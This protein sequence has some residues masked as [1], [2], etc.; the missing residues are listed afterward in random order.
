ML[1]RN[2]R[3]EV[4]EFLPKSEKFLV[5][6]EIVGGSSRSAQFNK[7]SSLRHH[8]PDFAI[9]RVLRE[10]PGVTPVAT[11]PSWIA[12]AQADRLFRVEFDARLLHFAVR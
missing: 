11:G 1:L 7:P 12:P 10:R 8:E 4:L 3:A 6:R 5:R 9:I 2:F